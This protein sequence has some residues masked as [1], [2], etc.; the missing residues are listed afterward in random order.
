[1]SGFWCSSEPAAIAIEEQRQLVKATSAKRYSS[2][3]QKLTKQHY[4]RCFKPCGLA[5]HAVSHALHAAPSKE[6]VHFVVAARHIKSSRSSTRHAGPIATAD[7]LHVIVF[8]IMYTSPI[9]HSNGTILNWLQE[10]SG[11]KCY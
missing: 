1:M 7:V 9:I 5:L 2:A 6:S 4:K 11:T 8:R 3:T 10:M